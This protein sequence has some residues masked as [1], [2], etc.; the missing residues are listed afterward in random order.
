MNREGW[1]GSFDH[2]IKIFP[3]SDPPSRLYFVILVKKSRDNNDDQ[4][5][6]DDDSQQQPDQS[7]GTVLSSPIHWDG[8]DEHHQ[9]CR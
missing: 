2:R 6:E 5:T 3:G 1:I 4:V 9:Q 7:I 8:G